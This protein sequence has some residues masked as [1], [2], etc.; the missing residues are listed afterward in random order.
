MSKNH[1]WKGE[2]LTQWKT[3]TEAGQ[4]NGPFCSFPTKEYFEE[5]WDRFWWIA[6]DPPSMFPP[7]TSYK[8]ELRKYIK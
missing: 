8:E 5:Q 6:F 1:W 4:F 7:A 2:D 3:M